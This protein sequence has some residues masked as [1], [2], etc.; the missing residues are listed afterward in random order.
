VSWRFNAHE[1]RL[2]FALPK[3]LGGRTYEVPLDGGYSFRGLTSLPV[4]V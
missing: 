4:V 1:K 3:S 2:R